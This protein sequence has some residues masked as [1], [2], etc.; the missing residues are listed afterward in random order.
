MPE[1][2]GFAKG[3]YA[4]Y[5]S[6]EHA[7]CQRVFPGALI[8]REQKIGKVKDG[9][10]KTIVLA[11]VRTRDDLDDER[12]A[13]ALAWPA[14]SIL[15]LDLHSEALGISVSCDTN[16][17]ISTPY[18]PLRTAEAASQASP[19]NNPVGA[20]NADQLRTCNEMDQLESDLLNMPCDNQGFESAAPRSLHPGG[21]NASNLDGSVRFIVPMTLMSRYLLR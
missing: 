16:T 12:G 4:A 14:A 7:N 10:S 20:W 6:P 2:S 21:V 18:S 1:F 15:A 8:N 9:A 5:V 13:W 11:E 19:P 3:N 17:P